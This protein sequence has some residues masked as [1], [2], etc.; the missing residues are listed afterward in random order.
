MT[1]ILAYSTVASKKC[2]IIQGHKTH[3]LLFVA[4]LGPQVPKM[5]C[6]RGWSST[7]CLTSVMASLQL[8][9]GLENWIKKQRLHLLLFQMNLD[10]YM[11]NEMSESHHLGTDHRNGASLSRKSWQSVVLGWRLGGT[12]IE[13]VVLVVTP[14]KHDDFV[15]KQSS[16]AIIFHPLCRC[17]TRQV[18]WAPNYDQIFGLLKW[19]QRTQTVELLPVL[20]YAPSRC[21]NFSF[22]YSSL[23]KEYESF[24]RKRRGGTGIR[25]RLYPKPRLPKDA[26][27]YS[28]WVLSMQSMQRKG[29]WRSVTWT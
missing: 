8:K 25:P 3:V 17:R 9:T 24:V 23:W 5:L 28:V 7:C 2:F 10:D 22:F 18:G 19:S 29:C 26:S 15:Q 27:W 4:L 12:P 16:E 20:T 11:S 21:T 13:F 1:W 6:S 14:A